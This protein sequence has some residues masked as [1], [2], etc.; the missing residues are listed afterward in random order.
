M[1]KEKTFNIGDKVEFTDRRTKVTRWGTIFD[2]VIHKSGRIQYFI[3]FEGKERKGQCI[4][5]RA[6]ELTLIK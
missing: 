1:S 5:K 4:V 6:K 3:H 2:S